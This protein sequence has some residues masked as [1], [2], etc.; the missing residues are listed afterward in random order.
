MIIRL[1]NSV[2]WFKRYQYTQYLQRWNVGWKTF[3]NSRGGPTKNIWYFRFYG[4]ILLPPT[5]KINYVNM[6]HNYVNMRLIYVDMQLLC[7]SMYVVLVFVFFCFIIG[8]HEAC[9]IH[10]IFYPLLLQKKWQT[11]HFSKAAILFC[12]FVC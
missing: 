6:Q 3:K 2:W 7:E 4:G 5:C 11:F 8:H 1:P 10:S 12:Y 9:C